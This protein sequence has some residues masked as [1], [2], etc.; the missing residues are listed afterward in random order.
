MIDSVED[1]RCSRS[2]RLQR[3]GGWSTDSTAFGRGLI[4]SGSKDQIVVSLHQLRKE[5]QVDCPGCK[6]GRATT[7]LVGSSGSNKRD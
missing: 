3:L 6:S 1:D 2:G 4:V 7:S 5:E